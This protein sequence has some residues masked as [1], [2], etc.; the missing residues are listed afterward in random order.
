[1][2][3]AINSF[4]RIP[5]FIGAL[6]LICTSASAQYIAA[7]DSHSLTLCT[8]S[9]VRAVGENGYGQLG[10]GTT[11]YKS[12]PVQVSVLTGITAVAGGGNHS[13]FLK[14]DGTVWA[15]G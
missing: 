2:K 3:K 13:L 9:T 10:D 1:M 11:T 15:V 5:V 12:T 4:I 8:D 14:N 7:G 6:L